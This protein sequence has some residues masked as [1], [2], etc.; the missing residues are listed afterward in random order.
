MV[1]KFKSPKIDI[2][3]AV[4]QSIRNQN[5]D[6]I[7]KLFIYSQLLLAMNKNAALYATTG[8]A[9]K[10]WSLW[11]EPLMNEGEVEYN[12]L[13]AIVKKDLKNSMIHHISQSMN[14]SENVFN[15][16]RLMTEQDKAIYSLCRPERLLSL[17]FKYIVFD[18]GIKKIARYQQYFVIQSTVKRVVAGNQHKGSPQ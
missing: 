12:R 11:K 4:S 1:K 16:K 3:Q 15:T 18:G 6:Y 13:E 2:K 8:T 14:I 5:D 17:T 9:A 10:F 7:P